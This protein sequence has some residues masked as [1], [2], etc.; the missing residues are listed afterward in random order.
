[1]LSIIAMKF[2][3]SECLCIAIESHSSALLKSL[4]EAFDVQ[5]RDIFWAPTPTWNSWTMC[6]DEYIPVLHDMGP[7]IDLSIVGREDCCHMRVDVELLEPSKLFG[8]T[9][10]YILVSLPMI[11]R[12]HT[13]E[14]F[15]AEGILRQSGKFDYSEPQFFAVQFFNRM[16]I[17]RGPLNVFEVYNEYST[18]CEYESKSESFVVALDPNK[19]TTVFYEPFTVMSIVVCSLVHIQ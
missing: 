10:A 12:W 16:R 9:R 7:E 11:A 4:L 8:K 18:I 6:E 5:Y 1:M 17:V 13:S 14:R 15:N 19:E 2:G 3:C